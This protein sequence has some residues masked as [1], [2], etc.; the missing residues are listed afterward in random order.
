MGKANCFGYSIG[1]AQYLINNDNLADWRT[2]L[3][4]DDNTNYQNVGET[5]FEVLKGDV[6]IFHDNKAAYHMI[7]ITDVDDNGNIT[8]YSNN[9]SAMDDEV[10]T[11]K[12]KSIEEIRK[13]FSTQFND[14]A[15]WSD[16]NVDVFRKK[17]GA[18]DKE[19][20]HDGT[21]YPEQSPP[22]GGFAPTQY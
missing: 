2:F 22:P 8:A 18:K 9:V 1:D 7:T 6:L 20:D 14:G 15:D 5:K 17:A 4:S 13:Q 21:G 10:A 11:L 19:Y 12:G 3:V 16:M